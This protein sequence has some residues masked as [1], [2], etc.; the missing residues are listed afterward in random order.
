MCPAWCIG[1]SAQLGI[2]FPTRYIQQSQVGAG[3]LTDDVKKKEIRSPEW[4][5]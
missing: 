3:W 4:R 5:E 1:F 2:H